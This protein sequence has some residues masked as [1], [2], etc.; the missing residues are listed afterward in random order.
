MVWE[1]RFRT[2]REPLERYLSVEGDESIG[3]PHWRMSFTIRVR[4]DAESSFTLLAESAAMNAAGLGKY[5]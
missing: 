2:Y 4:W 3:D 5:F 1:L